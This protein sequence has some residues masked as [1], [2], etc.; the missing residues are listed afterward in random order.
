MR[1]FTLREGRATKRAAPLARFV[2]ESIPPGSRD[3][4]TVFPVLFPMRA[5]AAR[6]HEICETMPIDPTQWRVPRAAYAGLV[7]PGVERAQRD[8]GSR[9]ARPPA[10]VHGPDARRGPR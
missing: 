8:A 9:H 7:V 5:S 1:K 2:L 3:S 6:A 10:S 4:R